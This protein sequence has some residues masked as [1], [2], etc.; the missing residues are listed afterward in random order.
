ME[1]DIEMQKLIENLANSL[2]LA[3]D[4]QD[5]T[6][7]ALRARAEAAEAEVR[8]LTA[9]WEPEVVGKLR[10]RVEELEGSI[11]TYLNNHGPSCGCSSA[12]NALLSQPSAK[13][14]AITDAVEIL[15]RRYPEAAAMAEEMGDDDA[16]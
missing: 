3:V 9:L 16:D 4:R 2:G 11:R 13:G 1:R 6:I 7:K 5:A 14:E 8:R 15:K 10:A 12:M